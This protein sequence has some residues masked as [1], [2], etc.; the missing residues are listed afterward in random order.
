MG[1]DIDEDTVFC[2][3]YIQSLAAFI[4]SLESACLI[5]IHQQKIL[6]Y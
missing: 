5:V 1:L 4:F 2:T 3:D 6:Y